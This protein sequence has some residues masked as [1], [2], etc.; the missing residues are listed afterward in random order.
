MPRSL[1]NPEVQKRTGQIVRFQPTRLEDVEQSNNPWPVQEMERVMK[2]QEVIMKAIA[3]KLKWVQAAEILGVSDRTMRRWR[4]RLEQD[5]Y[6]GLYD[7]RLNQPSP[8]RLPVATLE[9]VLKLY[10]EK[11]FDLNIRHFHE[12]LSEV[13]K[14]EVSYTWLRMALQ[15]AGLVD[16]GHG[17]GRRHQRDLL[18]AFGPRGVHWTVMDALR[19]VIESKGLFCSLY[20]D[21][22]SH[23]FATRKG[24]EKV[25]PHRLTQVG[26]A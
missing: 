14:V 17:A 24:G 11:Y 18:C 9:K 10:Q 25:H 7:Y 8:K 1:Y 13:E 26:R 5:G 16:K 15:A 22:G 19:S 23:F 21:R 3:G 12:K 20:S 2:A 6:D 4:D